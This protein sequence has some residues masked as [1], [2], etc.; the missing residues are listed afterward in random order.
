MA[1]KRRQPTTADAQPLLVKQIAPRRVPYGDIRPG[2]VL[3]IHAP[4]SVV[5]GRTV[6]ILSE[7][8]RHV[9]AIGVVLGQ[10]NHY[11]GKMFVREVFVTHVLRQSEVAIGKPVAGSHR[12]ATGRE[13]ITARANAK[14][15]NYAFVDRAANLVGSEMG[16]AR[17]TREQRCARFIAECARELRFE[18]ETEVPVTS[19]NDSGRR[20]YSRADVM[21]CLPVATRGH[22][23]IVVETEWSTPGGAESAAQAWEYAARLRKAKKFAD[24]KKR[25]GLSARDIDR[26]T[27]WP[28]V[29]AN[30]VPTRSLAADYLRV[31]RMD[32]GEFLQMLR[33]NRFTRL[34][35]LKV[36]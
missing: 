22:R 23:I 14:R 5:F 24:G 11:K 29:V 20:T 18:A 32:Y 36:S 33:G 2:V 12:I 10:P 16:P 31:E 17:Q 7:T 8:G 34:K 4:D 25:F 21:I 28:V 6:L 35:A 15:S 19:S 26:A 13:A 3:K 27:L 1:K 9:D 30:Q